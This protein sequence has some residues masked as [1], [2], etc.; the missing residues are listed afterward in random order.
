MF[1]NVSGRGATRICAL[2]IVLFGTAV[3]YAQGIIGQRVKIDNLAGT[4][5]TYTAQLPTTTPLGTAIT[6]T[7]FDIATPGAGRAIGTTTSNASAQASSPTWVLGGTVS[8]LVTACLPSATSTVDTVNCALIRYVGTAKNAIANSPSGIS[9]QLVSPAPTYTFYDDLNV[10]GANDREPRSG[11]TVSWAARSGG[12]FGGASSATS[13][14]GANGV[15]SIAYTA[16][17]VTPTQVI[18]GSATG[19]I[20]FN[21]ATGTTFPGIPVISITVTAAS[22]IAPTAK[23]ELPATNA[24]K[25]AGDTL[26]FLVRATDDVSVARVD[27]SAT[28]LLPDA[29]AVA[30]TAKNGTKALAVP[31]ATAI[32]TDSKTIPTNGNDGYDF[33]W[34]NLPVGQYSVTAIAT[35]NTGTASIVSA[36]RIVTVAANNVL[37]TAS[38]TR[39]SSN[40]DAFEGASLPIRV[41]ATDTDGKIASVTVTVVKD[42]G[43]QGGGAS[44]KATAGTVFT[45]TQIITIQNAVGYDFT[46]PNLPVGRYSITATATDNSGG[47]ST[48]SAKRI[49]TVAAAVAGSIALINPTVNQPFEQDKDV[50]ISARI[51]LPSS[52]NVS[53]VIATI[54]PTSATGSPSKVQLTLV[55]GSSRT[56]Q[57]SWKPTAAGSYTVSVKA[58]FSTGEFS[59]DKTSITLTEPQIKAANIDV[60]GESAIVIKPGLPVS[61]DVIAKDAQDKVAPGQLLEWSLKLKPASA[62]NAKQKAA[63][64]GDDSATTGKVKTS[65]NGTARIAFT[66]GSSTQDRLFEVFLIADPTIKKTATLKVAIATPPKLPVVVGKPI[67][68]KPDGTSET[69]VVALNV[70]KTPIVGA[71]FDWSLEPSNAGERLSINTVTNASGESSAL[72]R[73]FPTFKSAQLKACL[74]GSDKAPDKCALFLL[75]NKALVTAELTQA[76]QALVKPTATQ[77]LATSRVQLGQL[78]TRFQQIRNEQSGGYSNGVGVNVEGGRIPLPSGDGT[79]SSSSSSSG[80]STERDISTDG[81]KGSRWG[82]FSLGDIDVSRTTGTSGSSANALSNSLKSGAGSDGQNR[83]DF[84]LSTQGLTVG[85]DYRL[86][87]SIVI[88]AALGGLRG[89]ATGDGTTE[90]RARGVS[91]SL[92]AQWFTPG[93][94]YV[95]TVINYGRNSYDLRRFATP[96]IRIDSDTSSTQ[97]ALQLEGGYNYVRDNLGAS[98]YLRV[99]Y[100]RA[101]I[102]GINEP[103]NFADAIQTSTSTL[104]ANTVA[105]GLQGD[106]KF[107]TSNGVW[108]PGLRVE[109]LREKQKQSLTTARLINGTPLPT[110]VP[111]DPYDSSYGNA[112]L[113]LQWLTGIGAQPISV[114]FGYDTTFGKSGVSTKR[115]SAGVKVPL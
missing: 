43:E 71:T 63:A 102:G 99:E 103:T 47:T 11:V 42:A 2:Q 5:G 40:T 55:A 56:Y 18:A 37:P 95:N 38:I 25:Q 3:S 24:N 58:T 88:G 104:R 10:N 7:V 110:T 68:D 59:T 17:S 83:G 32:W 100:V 48:L 1:R 76:T 72:Y 73:L 60:I 85:V 53:S 9:G 94:F 50:A 52:G 96:D 35:D 86:R 82:A 8:G 89:K 26:P 64:D 69:T 90:Q 87:P 106:M 97:T 51:T 54:T 13:I 49:V 79:S 91:G 28:P 67:V 45:Q 19:P 75:T 30:A 27:I 57:G 105:L 66:A 61:F 109:Y 112:G 77:S 20:E 14:S 6:W 107:S 44:T 22:N 115:F 81:I 33:T 21:L 114:F 62:S 29:A 78:R 12:T 80:G 36:A 74:V 113:S 23:I 65:D 31:T 101:A 84:E 93:E 111:V 46:W 108:I 70:D 4:S 15:A 34:T 39:P 41:Q 98:P 92:F 16:G